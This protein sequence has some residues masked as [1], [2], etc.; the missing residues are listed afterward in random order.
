MPGGAHRYHFGNLSALPDI[1]NGVK[2][3]KGIEANILN[4]D[5]ELDFPNQYLTIMDFVI[6]SMHREV[7][8]PADCASNTAALINAA[9]NPTVNILGHPT[10]II[11]EIDIEAVVKAA[12]KT[13]TI[14]EINEQ[15]LVPGSFRFYG[16]EPLIEMLALCKEYGAQIIASSDA[17]Y[18]TSVGDFSRSK[19]LII[20]AGIPEEQI[21]N[22]SAERF[23]NA[24][25]IKRELMK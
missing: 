9:E 10:N 3:L 12:A 23:L 4:R 20:A 11:Y 16:E 7:I 6:A 25:K 14:I 2:I 22:T 21:V 15:S 13:H 19:P 24:V 8:I 5:G 18:H 1:I 17:H